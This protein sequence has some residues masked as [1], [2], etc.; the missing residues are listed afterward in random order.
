MHTQDNARHRDYRLSADIGGTFTDIVLEGRGQRW[1]T[2]T[3]TRYDAPEQAIITGL[4][5]VLAD[6]G[7]STADVG[8]FI[9][10]MTLA[11]NAVLERR[12]ALTAFLTTKGFRDVLE[13]GYETRYAPTD[14]MLVKQSP[15]VP[16]QRRLVVDERVSAKGDVLVPLDE[17]AFDAIAERLTQERVESVAIGFLHAYANSVHE[18]RAR[19]LLLQRMPGLSISLSS[20]VCPEIREYERFSTVVANAYVQPIVERYLNK[21]R[22]SLDE[23]GLTAPALL[24]GSAG[25]VMPLDIAKRIPIRLIESGPAGGAVL[26]ASIAKELKLPKVLSFDMGGTTAKICFIQNGEP[27]VAPLFE[28]DRQSRF[29]KGS[30]LPLRTPVVELVEIGAGG[31]S[32]ASLDRMNRIAV[33]PR[34][35]ASEPGP[36]CYGRGG[37]E[38]TVTDS[39]L[40]MGRLD[41]HNFAGGRM[42][43]NTSASEVAIERV[44]GDALSLS[45]TESAF[46]VVEI[47]DETMANAARVHAAELGRELSEHVIIAFGGAAPLHAG[48]LAEKLGIDTIIIP[49][50]AGVGSALGFLRAPIAVDLVQT[51]VTSLTSFDAATVNQLLD[52]MRKRVEILAG[53]LKEQEHLT[54]SF[55]CAMRYRGQGYEIAVPIERLPATVQ[56]LSHAFQAEYARLFGRIIPDG[57]IEVVSWQLRLSKATWTAATASD[58]PQARLS[59]A[60]FVST[61][62]IFEPRIGSMVNHRIYERKRMNVGS[63]FTGPAMIFEDETSTVVP[64]SFDG[65]VDEQGN[66][67]LTKKEQA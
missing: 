62:E 38:P 33:G 43:L 40:I 63:R 14:L 26:S 12:G 45:T 23:I 35:A 25:G 48:R 36:A 31:G 46:G 57:E 5:A 2:K 54:A 39:D 42:P 52:G 34:S 21:L 20:E 17:C 60:E 55:S 27:H 30:G 18:E 67:V 51:A 6:A 59:E 7:I 28:V 29:Q 41:P 53:D 19:E 16:R 8:I 24:M 50:N 37:D 10:G 22:N 64:A 66:L 9:H 49:R 44:I 4:Q 61:R 65:H 47:V 3:L 13:I 11:T 32:I 56:S 1:S 15:L 58:A